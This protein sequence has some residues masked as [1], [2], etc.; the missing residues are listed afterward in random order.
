MR[1][2]VS[3]KDGIVAILP[4]NLPERY[5]LK[6]INEKKS[7]LQQSLKKQEKHKSQYTVFT[8]DSVYKTQMHSLLLRTHAKNTIKSVVAGNKIVVWY[9]TS[10]E[11]QD[12]RIQRVIRKAI[13]E[14]WRIEAK[15]FLPQRVKELAEQ[16]NFKYQKL[17]VKNAKTRWGS[18]SSKNNINL[19]LQL[20]RLPNELID[21]VILHELNHTVHRHHQK[22]FWSSLEQILPG[23]RK[24]DKALNK[25]HLE[26]W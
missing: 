11:V 8:H 9:P 5:A 26:Y 22:T 10:A 23:S 12:E 16:F 25:Y 7:W 6:F 20:M 17:T 18:C 13:L 3:P 19:N 4:E 14:A 2:R 21:Y 1:L 24:L 15:K